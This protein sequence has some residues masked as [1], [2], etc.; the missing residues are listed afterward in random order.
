M[1]TS[2]A[3]LRTPLDGRPVD[4]LLRE[5]ARELAPTGNAR[6]DVVGALPPLPPL[7]AAHAI[8][9]PPRR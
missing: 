8:A 4:E 7:L 2:V 1:E 9:S 3:E 6:I 5:R